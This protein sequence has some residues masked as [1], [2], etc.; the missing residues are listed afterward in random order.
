VPPGAAGHDEDGSPHGK[1][2]TVAEPRCSRVA[3]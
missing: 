3:S 1:L 2:L